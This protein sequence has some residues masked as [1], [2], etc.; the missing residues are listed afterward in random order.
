LQ[1]DIGHGR[2]H[3]GDRDSQLQPARIVGAMHHIGRGDVAI[4]VRN[5]PQHR[6]HCKYEGIDDDGVGQREEAIGANRIDQRRH[7]NYSIGGVE[8]AADQE[9][10]DPGAELTAAQSPFVEV[11]T[12]GTRFPARGEKAHHGHERKKEDED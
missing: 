12:D 6:H 11:F 1:R 4:G 7:R 3:A 5:L 9:P 2:D 10:G 8:I